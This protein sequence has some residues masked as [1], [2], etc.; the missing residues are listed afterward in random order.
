MK[1]TVSYIAK[2]G[3]KVENQIHTTES[4]PTLLKNLIEWGATNITICSIDEQ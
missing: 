3:H 2:D 4:I 1:F